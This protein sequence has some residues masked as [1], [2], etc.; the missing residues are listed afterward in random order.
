M[1]RRI[2]ECTILMSTVYELCYYS[3]T[4]TVTLTALLGVTFS[5]R[6]LQ[7]SVRARSKS[8]P[9]RKNERCPD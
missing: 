4:D 2:Y 3:T 8:R 7:T 9:C 1:L 6:M 5:M